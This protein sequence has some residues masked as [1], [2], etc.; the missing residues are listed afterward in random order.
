[1][2]CN[3]ATRGDGGGVGG[4]S[5]DRALWDAPVASSTGDL[6]ADAARYERLAMLPFDHERQLVSVL[7]KDPVGQGLLVTKGA[8]EVL[9]SKCDQVPSAAEP[10]LHGLFSEGARVIAVATRPPRALSAS[11][12]PEDE[13]ALTL[14]GFLTFADR[15]KLDAGPSIAQLERLGIE[16][17]IITGDNGLVAAKVCSDIGLEVPRRADRRRPRRPRR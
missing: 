14:V 3:E 2:L 5:L 9:L 10:V 16:V 4:N 7:V 12:S 13:S 8:P 17:K 1:M 6:A 11:L 15:P